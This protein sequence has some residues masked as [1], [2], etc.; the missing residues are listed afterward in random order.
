MIIICALA[1]L[2]LLVV[3]GGVQILAVTWPILL[4][5]VGINGLIKKFN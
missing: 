5:A 1:L 3:I 2:G 4:I